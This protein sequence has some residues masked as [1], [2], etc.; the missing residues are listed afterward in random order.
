MAR[1]P[2][3]HF[4]S[5]NNSKVI[6]DIENFMKLLKTRI[7]SNDNLNSGKFIDEY[8]KASKC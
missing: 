6:S 2:K 7:S 5:F 4:L 1:N 3:R 8:Y